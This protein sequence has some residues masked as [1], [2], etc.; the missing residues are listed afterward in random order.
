MAIRE[1]KNNA[2]IK[3]NDT[4]KILKGRDKDKKGKVL[5]VRADKERAINEG[6]NIAKKHQRRKRKN[7]QLKIILKNKLPIICNSGVF[8][9][10]NL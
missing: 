9:V 2:N 1:L 6:I 7:K 10:I 8:C 4:V 3:K 5:F